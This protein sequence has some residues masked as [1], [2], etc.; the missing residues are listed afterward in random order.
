MN[1]RITAIWRATLFTG[2]GALLMLVPGVNALI[3]VGV[4]L[5]LWVMNDLGVPGLGSAVNGFFMPS[6]IGWL[7]VGLSFWSFCFVL[8]LGAI[9]AAA[10]QRQ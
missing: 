2:V 8:S 6:V 10:R 9:R 3:L 1:P 4:M 5:P 7:L